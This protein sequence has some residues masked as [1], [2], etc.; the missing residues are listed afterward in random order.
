[1]NLPEISNTTLA[2]IARLLI[3]AAILTAWLLGK[4]TI[5]EAALI[6]TTLVS[7]VGSLGLFAARDDKAPETIAKVDVVKSDSGAK[8]EIK[9]KTGD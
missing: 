5:G 3:L 1:M 6:A 9:A 7:I 2:G 8:V 4:V